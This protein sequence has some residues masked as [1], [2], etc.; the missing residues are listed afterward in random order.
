MKKT[1]IKAILALLV[2][3]ALPF[4]SLKAGLGPLPSTEPVPWRATR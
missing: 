1:L 4:L 2:L 3:A